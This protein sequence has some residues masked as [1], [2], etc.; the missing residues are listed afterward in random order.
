M[1]DK[2]GSLEI[3]LYAEDLKIYNEIKS[4]D[5]VEDLQNGRGNLY[6]WTKYSLLRFHLGKCVTMRLMPRQTNTQLFYN[7]DET[8]LRTVN[9]EQDLGLII[10]N[11]GEKSKCILWY[12]KKNFCTSP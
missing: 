4:S 11:E 8:K 1:V 7:I 3:Y 10:D 6:D 5:D 9:S 2:A 12:A